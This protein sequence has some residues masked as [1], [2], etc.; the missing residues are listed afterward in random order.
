MRPCALALLVLSHA[1]VAARPFT[2]EELLQ[3]RRLDGV[4]ASPEG[5]FVAFT[6]RQK[7]L[8]E[9]R[10]LK[11]IWVVPFSRGAAGPARQLTRDGRSEDPRW[12]PDGRSLLFTSGRAEGGQLFVLDLAG[13]DARQLTSL[14]GGADNG[15]FSADGKQIAFTSTVFAS[16]APPAGPADPAAADLCNRQRTEEAAQSK[17]KARIADRLFVRHWTEWRDGK[18]SHVFVVPVAGGAPRDVTP[19]DSDWPAW[20]LGGGDDVAFS[21][22]GSTLYVSHKEAAREAW[23]TNGDIV[24][25]PL[26][27]GAARNLTAGNAGDDAQPRESPD[28]RFLAWLSQAREGYESDQWKLKLLDKQTG[29]TVV[30][31][32]FDDDV[33]A[34][35][36]RRD[37]AGI[38]AS[39]VHHG[40]VYLNSV[41]FDGKVSRFNP[42]PA[43]GEFALGLDGAAAVVISGMNRPPEL[44]RLEARGEPVRL[45]SFNQEQYAGLDLGPAPEDLWVVG[46]DG[47]RVH[48]FV[49]KPPGLAAGK[50]AP[51]LVLIHGGPQGS[52]E[53]QWGMRWNEAAFAARGSVVLAV[54]PRGSIGYGHAFEE[55]ITGDWGGLAYDDLLR[56]VDAAE[57]LPFVAPGR[58]CAAG[59]SFGGYMVDWIAGHTDRFK[60]LVTHDGVF[61]LV[62]MY[63]STEELWFPEWELRGPY[64]EQPEAYRKWSPS[65]YAAHFRT[66]TLVVQGELD[67]R[68]PAEQGMG[69]FTALQRRGVESRLLWFPDE[70]HW[71]Q[72]PR[73]SALWY[74]TVLDWID[75]HAKAAAGGKPP[76]AAGLN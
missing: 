69:M 44:Y 15:I 75:A 18:R 43:G 47:A 51:L 12:S 3:T 55:Q 42:A 17:V 25:L 76:G 52:W 19:G 50:R 23:S 7:G 66:P 10:D 58:T 31:G 67:F 33:G 70:G 63:G 24:A 20:R 14:S 39:V 41:S 49:L 22:D 8:A 27:G 35:Q 36:F 59:A 56:S 5:K 37:G 65:T 30:A 64:W 13:G 60:C 71:V 38:V 4:Q 11:D 68:V 6:V 46:R 26:K 16:C 73:N 1:A 61:D 32:D 54:D 9:N 28:G 29:K 40:R 34:F 45:T 72:K 57:K 2:P 48:S 21:V 62:S 74:H 53:D